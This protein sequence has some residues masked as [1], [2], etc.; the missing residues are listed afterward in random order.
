MLCGA[1]LL[2]GCHKEIK[3]DIADL[4]VD[5]AALWA[6]INELKASLESTYVTKADLQLV[7]ASL[8]DLQDA[9]KAVETLVGSKADASALEAAVAA[10]EA[11]LAGFVTAED[12]EGYV[13][14][15][16][17]ATTEAL[18]TLVSELQAK[19]EAAIAELKEQIASLSGVNGCTC[20][21][22]TIKTS[23]S[24]LADTLKGYE[25][26]LAD[27]MAKTDKAI[28]EIKAQIEKINSDEFLADIISRLD[29]QDAA[30]DSLVAD[31]TA[32]NKALA[33]A[34]A[35]AEEALEAAKEAYNKANSGSSGSS[36][37]NS[38]SSCDCPSVSSIINKVLDE[39][40]DEFENLH[41]VSAEDLKAAVEAY[42]NINAAIEEALKPLQDWAADREIVSISLIPEV[43]VNGANAVKFIA[44]GDDAVAVARYH[45]NPSTANIDNTTFQVVSNKAEIVTKAAAE[46]EAEL[47]NGELV[48]TVKRSDLGADANV[49]ALAATTSEATVYSE[50]AQVYE[51]EASDFVFVNP[52]EVTI[53]AGKAYDVA[54]KV[55]VENFDIAAHGFEYA[56]TIDGAEFTGT[57]NLAEGTYTV[58]VKV[59]DAEGVEVCGTELVINV[60]EGV[61]VATV[62]GTAVR[63]AFEVSDVKDWAVALKDQ[64]NTI[65]IIKQAAQAAVNR[66]FETAYELLGG[67]PGFVKKTMP[68]TGTGSSDAMMTPMM[69]PMAITIPDEYKD[70]YDN[71]PDNVK[72]II[73]NMDEETFEDLKDVVKDN[74]DVVDEIIKDVENAEDIT[75]II[76]IIGKDE[77]KDVI[78]SVTGALGDTNV[79]EIISGGL[80]DAVVDMLPSELQGL[81]DKVES[82]LPEGTDLMDT[83]ASL[84][85][86]V[87]IENLGDLL[88]K[89]DD[90][91]ALIE[92]VKENSGS[93][94]DAVK[95]LI[96]TPVVGDVISKLIGDYDLEDIKAKIESLDISSII[97]AEAVAKIK[98]KMTSILSAVK[99]Y[100]QN[101]KPGD[102]NTGD[103]N[104]GDD[105]TGDDNT[106]D[107]NTGDE[108]S[109]DFVIDTEAKRLA[110]E[111]ATENFW[112]NI[113]AANE[114]LIANLPNGAW[115]KL[116][117][118]LENEYVSTALEYVPEVKAAL[119]TF[120]AQA[121]SLVV[122][123]FEG[124]PKVV[125]LDVE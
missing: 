77:Y 3:Q 83:I 49:F 96:D 64:P 117:S 32:T 97:D 110:V 1:F 88:S 98:D 47:V 94:V 6:E 53:A 54:A 5:T 37:G 20:D 103:D 59:V 101:M 51:V 118:V 100:V 67:V 71:L 55:Y 45:V 116:L 85:E 8:T 75:D 36:S 114:A 76:D 124:T 93:I 91:M 22:E 87:G 102:D 63:Y 25:T 119:D 78:D 90:I 120:V 34:L 108:P 72:D 112:A 52:G 33:D 86:K 105:N 44:Y 10:L 115:G 7:S 41:G 62:E 29:A 15:G 46:V 27:Y 43:I 23:V 99:D 106:G 2:S 38:G 125:A 17:Y 69:V 9:V 89:T 24:A 40:E 122:Y 82:Y 16:E 19:A 80:G 66:D 58:A 13:K 57:E 107:D 65:E 81:I 74:Q 92:K 95:K 60:V 11:K 109:Q 21:L 30:I 28:E 35:K 113:E 68:F 104:T 18:Q 48:V 123:R 111:A 50:Y 31:L 84:V 12:L 56:Y 121:E 73:D 42:K 39:I 26:T 14:D 61:A 70:I 4:K 79:D